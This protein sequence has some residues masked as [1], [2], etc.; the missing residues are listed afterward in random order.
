MAIS[1]SDAN[2]VHDLEERYIECCK[3]EYIGTTLARNGV[4]GEVGDIGKHVR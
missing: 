4:A 2:A 1:S 3:G